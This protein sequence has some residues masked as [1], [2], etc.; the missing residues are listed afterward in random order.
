MIL[1]VKTNTRLTFS[2]RYDMLLKQGG[3]YDDERT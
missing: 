2:N 3:E 1:L